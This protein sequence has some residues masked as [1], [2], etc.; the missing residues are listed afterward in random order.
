MK[1]SQWHDYRIKPVRK[2]VY[3][4]K[5]TKGIKGYRREGKSYWNGKFWSE[6]A[7]SDREFANF[8]CRGLQNKAWRG[9][10]K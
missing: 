6:T 9:I 10:V 8:R 7:I 3:E 4:T 1:L 5:I 2:G